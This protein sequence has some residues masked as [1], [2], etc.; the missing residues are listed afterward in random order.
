MGVNIKSGD[1]KWVFVGVVVALVVVVVVVVV[2]ASGP[3]GSGS[4]HGCDVQ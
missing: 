4:V 2:A 3:V 1:K